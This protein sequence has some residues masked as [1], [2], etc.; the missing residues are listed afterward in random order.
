MQ[1]RSVIRQLWRLANRMS[2]NAA[3][4]RESR[5]PHHL[6]KSRQRAIRHLQELNKI[7]DYW[8]DHKEPTR[9]RPRDHSPQLSYV[10]ESPV[11]G[12][13]RRLRLR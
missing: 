9:R 2:R 10:G 8:A 11:W 1:D 13:P 5:H 7:R 4:I 3:L 12:W 6:A